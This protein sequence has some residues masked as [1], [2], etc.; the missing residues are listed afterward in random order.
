L[1]TFSISDKSPISLSSGKGNFF[2]NT[3][4]ATS[5]DVVQLVGLAKKRVF[6]KYGIHLSE[7]IH[8]IGFLKKS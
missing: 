8:Y 2:I 5:E 4:G 6:E 7:E 1:R 3:G